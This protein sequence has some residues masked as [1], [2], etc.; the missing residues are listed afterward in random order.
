[1]FMISL[2]S[3]LLK[4]SICCLLALFTLSPTT[5]SIK[6]NERLKF[7][8]NIDFIML[9]IPIIYRENKFLFLPLCN[10]QLETHLHT[11]FSFVLSLGLVTSH[12][13]VNTSLNFPSQLFA[14]PTNT[15]F[16]FQIPY[17]TNSTRG[18]DMNNAL[19]RAFLTTDWR[20]WIR[21]GEP[22]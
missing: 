3:I 13:I 17:H 22:R 4:L 20:R 7:G 1:M 8:C 6:E 14:W 15:F 10:W 19:L 12:S 18:P 5:N 11:L 2:R 9:F 21:R 16:H